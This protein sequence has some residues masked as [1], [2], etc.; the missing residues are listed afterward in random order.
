MRMNE[1]AG[2]SDIAHSVSQ[3][4]IDS[5]VLDTAYGLQIPIFLLGNNPSI[6]TR[7]FEI[8]WLASFS[9]TTMDRH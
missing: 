7:E 8:L 1:A 4:L 9:S 2:L 6:E 5:P 3:W